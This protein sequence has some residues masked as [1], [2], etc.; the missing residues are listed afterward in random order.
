MSTTE[1]KNKELVRNCVNEVLSEG[2]FSRLDEYFAEDYVEHT[3]AAPENIEGLDAIREHYAGIREAFPDFDVEIEALIAEGNKVVQRSDQ[4]G[5]HKGTFMGV[6][7]TGNEV[8]IPGI[9]I[10]QIEDG[11]IVEAWVQ[12]DMMG[13][14][15]QL[16]VVEAPGA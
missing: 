2:D 3:S 12:A 11:K 9:V 1:A 4:T 5:T 14:M 13:V 15:Q 16:G 8:S 6:E 7:P 10:Y